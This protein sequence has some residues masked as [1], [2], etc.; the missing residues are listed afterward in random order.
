MFRNILLPIDSY[1][2][3]TLQPIYQDWLNDWLYTIYDEVEHGI[4]CSSCCVQA[5]IAEMCLYSQPQNDW[6]EIMNDLL[7][8]RDNI[9]AYSEECGKLLYKFDSQWRQSPIYAIYNRWWIE[10]IYGLLDKSDFHYGDLIL[11]YV[12]PSGW[13]FNPNVSD[14]G[15]PWR[16]KTELLMSLAMS[17]EILDYYGLLTER[18][19]YFESLLASQPVHP[20]ISAEYFRMCALSKLRSLTQRPTDLNS[21]LHKCQ[22]GFGFCDFS[23][24]DK[25]DEYMGTRSRTQRDVTIHSPLI[26]LYALKLTENGYAHTTLEV[27]NIIHR[28]GEHLKANPFDIPAFKMRDIDIPFGTDLS[29]LEIISASEIIS[30]S[31]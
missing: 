6:L 5:V 21:V 11:Q 9:L 14:T 20:Y 16:M 23:L 25:T 30:L 7:V 26:S 18:R 1:E 3:V 12:Q 31:K 15:V 29:P 19:S 10:L 8:D 22:S 27:E 2:G 13:I 17:F 24:E 28:F 4:I